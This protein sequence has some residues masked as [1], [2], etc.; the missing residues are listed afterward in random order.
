[1]SSLI[2]DKD[3]ITA[4]PDFWFYGF[5]LS[6]H[7]AKVEV[8]SHT[9]VRQVSKLF[10]CNTTELMETRAFAQWFYHDIS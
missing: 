10:V 3:G 8:L 4:A 5:E 1:V 9:Y 7:H 6:L 2:D